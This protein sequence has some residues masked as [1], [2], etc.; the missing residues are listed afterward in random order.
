MTARTASS[1]PRRDALGAVVFV[2]LVALVAL[3]GSVAAG[4]S[5]A[6]YL[7]LRQ[8]PWA[9]PSWLF[10]PVWTALYVL[11]AVSGWLVWRTAGSWSAART[12]LGV[13]LGQ[14]ALNALWPALFFGFGLYGLAV[15][16]IVLLVIA[17]VLNI[18]LFHRRN[19]LAAWLLVPYL[20]WT[21]FATALNTSIWMLNS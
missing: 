12:E 20:A 18:V 4:S 15:V 11:I 17:V 6:E 1:S 10:G 14:L 7:G 19:R 21:V 16:E 2:L 13:Y 3:V 5:S 8:P 9:P